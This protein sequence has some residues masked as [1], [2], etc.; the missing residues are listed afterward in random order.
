LHSRDIRRPG[1]WS[2]QGPLPIRQGSISAENGQQNP[3]WRA[4]V[5]YEYEIAGGDINAI[6]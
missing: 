4:S 5:V 3:T 1:R 2:R 6:M